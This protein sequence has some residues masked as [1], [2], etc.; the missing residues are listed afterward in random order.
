MS[1]GDELRSTIMDMLEKVRELSDMI[2]GSDQVVSELNQ[3]A[4]MIGLTQSANPQVSSQMVN[5]HQI[6]QG[7]INEMGQIVTKYQAA[8]ES[9]LG[10]IS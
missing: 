3:E 4:I 8:L 7:Q 6:L 1:Q 5:I 10:D 2:V 9:Y